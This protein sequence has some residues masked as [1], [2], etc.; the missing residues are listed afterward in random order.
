MGVMVLQN[1]AHMMEQQWWR[2]KM[3]ATLVKALNFGELGSM[4]LGKGWWTLYEYE[5]RYPKVIVTSTAAKRFLL[6]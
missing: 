5:K 4:G 6:P 3:R 1:K 2:G